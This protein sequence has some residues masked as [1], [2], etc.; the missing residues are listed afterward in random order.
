MTGAASLRR[1]GRVRARGIARDRMK[2]AGGRSG[3]RRIADIARG[4]PGS[5]GIAA[6]R[7]GS[8]RFAPDRAV[9]TMAAMIPHSCSLLVSSNARL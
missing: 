2:I 6:D 8:L 7:A 9:G 1:R 3:S 4:R 5:R